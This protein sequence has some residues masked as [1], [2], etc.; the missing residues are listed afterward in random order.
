MR[1]LQSSTPES[2]ALS[3]ELRMQGFAFVGPTTIYAAMQALGVVDDHLRGFHWRDI[4]KAERA[5][6]E[7]PV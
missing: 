7:I 1:D 5:T 6:F 4:C 2:V 3:A